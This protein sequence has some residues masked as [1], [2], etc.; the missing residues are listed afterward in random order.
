MK[1]FIITIFTIF[2]STAT[3]FSQDESI[4]VGSP[5]SIS[6]IVETQVNS[7]NIKS[8]R[9]YPSTKRV[10]VY[11]SGGLPPMEMPESYF[12]QWKSAIRNGIA[13][14]IDNYISVNGL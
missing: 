1:Y 10:V 5:I 4:N 8:I 6:S 2:I 11:F 3:L 9:I 12:D 7:I 14:E 13:S